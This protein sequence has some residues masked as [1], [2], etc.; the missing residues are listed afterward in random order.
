MQTFMRAVPYWWHFAELPALIDWFKLSGDCARCKQRAPQLET[1]LH[2]EDK[3]TSLKE[4]TPFN[5]LV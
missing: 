5:K 4:Q 2:L 1:G 3:Q